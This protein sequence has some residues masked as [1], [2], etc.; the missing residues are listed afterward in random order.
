MTSTSGPEK[1][2]RSRSFFDRITEPF[3]EKARESIERVEDHVREAVQ[4]EI[5]AVASSV[6]A[7]AVE[8]RPSAIAFGIAALVTF[9]GLALFVTA[10]VLG[11]SHA[12]EPW[13]AALIIGVALVLVGAGAAAWGRRHLP[14]TGPAIS[15]VRV[16]EP[17][18]PAEEHVHPWED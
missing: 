5:N 3:T 8:V 14:Q 17:T 9:F 2:E 7:R 18:H 16:H 13:L 6:R 1:S 12:V 4:T 10:A 11:L 15:V